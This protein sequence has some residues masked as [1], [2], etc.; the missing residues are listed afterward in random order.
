MQTVFKSGV[1]TLLKF[2]PLL[3]VFL[4]I[5]KEKPIKTYEGKIFREKKFSCN[6]ISRFWV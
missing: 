4:L 6:L 2:S 1:L 5:F 3:T